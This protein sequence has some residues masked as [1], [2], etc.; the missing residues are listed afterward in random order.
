M[1]I[2]INTFKASYTRR[3]MFFSSNPDL[4]HAS[5]VGCYGERKK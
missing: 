5:A 3:R 2:A 4:P 1:S